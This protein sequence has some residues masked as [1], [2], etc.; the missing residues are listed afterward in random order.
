M[1][2]IELWDPASC[3]A[4]AAL[5]TLALARG[6]VETSREPTSR[7]LAD[8]GQIMYE[9]VEPDPAGSGYG[10]ARFFVDRVSI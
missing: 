2:T 9:E 7:V 8:D 10:E 3:S 5:R 4:A 1:V 6:G